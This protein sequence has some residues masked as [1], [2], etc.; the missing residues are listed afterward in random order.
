MS[1]TKYTMGL[2][3]A[4]ETEKFPQVW[5]SVTNEQVFVVVPWWEIMDGDTLLSGNMEMLEGEPTDRRFKIGA[6]A[7]VG[8]LIENRNGVFF[9][10][11]PSALEFM[12][13]VGE[14]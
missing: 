13:K 3:P 1:E 12:E 6:L 8:W 9:G 14:L 4:G 5:M 10:V 11:G 2:N 7:Q